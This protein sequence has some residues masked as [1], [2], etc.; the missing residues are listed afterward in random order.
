MFIRSIYPR[1]SNMK[2]ENK[3]LVKLIK[4]NKEFYIYKVAKCNIYIKTRK[5]IFYIQFL[6]VIYLISYKKHKTL[7][8]Y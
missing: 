3:F 1:E 7:C 6:L 8:Y 2:I 5:S 4:C